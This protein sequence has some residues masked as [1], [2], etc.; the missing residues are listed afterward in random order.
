MSMCRS[1]PAASYAYGYSKEDKPIRVHPG[2]LEDGA[3]GIKTS[4][5]DLLAFVKANIGGLMTRRF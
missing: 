1:R 3:Y 2:M 5:A 4:S